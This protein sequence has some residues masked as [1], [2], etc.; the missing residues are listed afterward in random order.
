MIDFAKAARRAASVRAAKVA[1]GASALAQAANEELGAADEEL[2]AA[3]GGGSLSLDAHSG[4]GASTTAAVE[5]G[6]GPGGGGDAPPSIGAMPTAEEVQA[7]LAAEIVAELKLLTELLAKLAAEL[8]ADATL[9][10]FAAQHEGMNFGG[11]NRSTQRPQNS[12]A[13]GSEFAS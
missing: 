6:V 3:A 4:L 9:E 5:A 7:E 10:K 11:E 2:G 13:G 8:E 1:V 12:R